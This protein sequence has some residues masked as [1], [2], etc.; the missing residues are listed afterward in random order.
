MESRTVAQSLR[1]LGSKVIAQAGVEAEA[2]PVL[3]GYVHNIFDMRN[4]AEGFRAST[5]F[6]V[7]ADTANALLLPRLY[8]ENKSQDNL[9]PE[10]VLSAAHITLRAAH[11]L[12]VGLFPSED[13]V[14]CMARKEE[15]AVKTEGPPLFTFLH[16]AMRMLRLTLDYMHAAVTTGATSIQTGLAEDVLLRMAGMQAAAGPATLEEHLVA[17]LVTVQTK[18][19]VGG[20]CMSTTELPAIEGEQPATTVSA[21]AGPTSRDLANMDAEMLTLHTMAAVVAACTRAGVHKTPQPMTTG[22]GVDHS[23][24]VAVLHQALAAGAEV[25]TLAL[26]VAAWGL[27]VEALRTPGTGG[28]RL[29]DPSRALRTCCGVVRARVHGSPDAPPM[30]FE[31]PYAQNIA[32]S[33]REAPLEGDPT[34]KQREDAAEAIG[35]AASLAGG[36]EIAGACTMHARNA[37]VTASALAG[38][39]AVVQAKAAT[40]DAANKAL[41]KGAFDVPAPASGSTW[42]DYTIHARTPLCTHAAA[43]L[44]S[45]AMQPTP[46]I[47]AASGVLFVCL[48]QMR[49][50]S[51]APLPTT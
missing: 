39:E 26:M 48:A 12:A 18:T 33:L 9:S 22:G 11:T 36:A 37:I 15:T 28:F 19:R 47:A 46:F 24:A 27:P 32:A 25:V 3:L 1:V 21:C 45:D 43:L 17:C 23:R 30:Q 2:Y 16:S 31:G 5:T 6:G 40:A 7:A 50:G 8:G 34:E 41:S 10:E 14:A 4:T 29:Q 42:L 20:W 44:D 13:F 49:L 38:L 51:A 35:K